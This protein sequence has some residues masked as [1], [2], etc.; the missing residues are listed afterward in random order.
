[1]KICRWFFTLRRRVFDKVEEEPVKKSVK[2][3][4]SVPPLLQEYYGIVSFKLKEQQKIINYVV[5]SKDE[6]SAKK[7]LENLIKID[8]PFNNFRYL[9]TVNPRTA[10]QRET[11]PDRKKKLRDQYEAWLKSIE[12]KESIKTWF[13]TMNLNIKGEKFECGRRQDDLSEP[14]AVESVRN[15]VKKEFSGIRSITK[16]KSRLATDEDKDFL[17]KIEQTKSP[18]VDKSDKKEESTF[19]DDLFNGLGDDLDN[20]CYKVVYT[21]R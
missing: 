16:V 15:R 18:V 19:Y 14:E 8:F 20:I 12:L 7:E 17:I 1:M 5:L 6:K 3:I 21:P 11:K 10:K 9:L 4:D 2:E 13:V